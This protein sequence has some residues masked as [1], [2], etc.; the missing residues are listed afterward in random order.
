MICCSTKVSPRLIPN[1]VVARPRVHGEV[2]P[3]LLAGQAEDLLEARPFGGRAHLREIARNEQ[4]PGRADP[5]ANRWRKGLA[6][7]VVHG[8]DRVAPRRAPAL[9]RG[10]YSWRSM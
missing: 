5:A 8:A 6:G 2:D 4:P 10:R 3:A 1:V 7:D 9:R